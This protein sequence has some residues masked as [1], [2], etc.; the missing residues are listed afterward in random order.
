MVNVFK[1]VNSLDQRCY[2]QLELSEDI[3]MENAGASISNYI[4]NNFPKNSSILIVAGSGNNGGDGAVVARQ[5]YQDYRVILYIASSPKSEIAKLQF[6]RTFAIGVQVIEDIEDINEVDV[7]IVVD[8][9][10]G[11]GLKG[12]LKEEYIRIIKKVNSLQ[13]FKIACDI[14]SGIDRDG[15]INS[16][17]IKCNT[18]ITMGAMKLS[19]LSDVAK[20]FVGDIVVADLGVSRSIYETSSDIY[21]LEEKDFHPPKRTTKNGH[22]GNF[23][24][25]VILSGDKVGASIISAL[26]SL[27]FGAGLV[28]VISKKEILNL[29]YELMQSRDI[30]TNTTAIAGGM[31]L[32]DEGIEFF[33]KELINSKFPLLLD[34]D[35]LHSPILKDIINKRSYNIVLTP[36]PREFQSILKNIFNLELSVSEIVQ[37]RVELITTFS[38]EFPHIVLLLKGANRVIGYRNKIYFDTLGDI[39]L[40]KGGS[41]DILSGLIVALLAQGYSPLQATISGSLALSL[42]SK[43][44]KRANFSLTPTK[45]ID[46]ISELF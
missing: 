6:K 24:H 19:L 11:T 17:A 40:A 43:N 42:I 27:N 8:A 46:G 5:L 32:G 21:L 25:S 29:P 7:D 16:N 26:S 10:L 31:G 45:I 38:K 14:P 34:A 18:T 23:G 2:N 20:D 37:R 36:H 39:N 30:P 1:D 22:K 3:L 28:T 44:Y 33:I 9:L 12:D 13:A 35:I 4:R 15:N 41:G